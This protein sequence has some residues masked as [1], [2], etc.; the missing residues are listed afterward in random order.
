MRILLLL[1]AALHVVPARSDDRPAL[2]V[3]EKISGSVGFYTAEGRRIGGVKVGVHPH[4]IILSPDRRYAYVSDNGILW[5]TNPGEGGNTISIVDV[6]SMKKAGVV[7]LGNYRRPHG[8]DMDPRTG[9]LVVTIEN[10][11]GLLLVDPSERKVVRKYDVE[12]GDPH[13]VT[14][15]RDGRYAFVSNTATNTIAAVQLDTGKV[16]LIPTDARPQGGV[17]SHDG[18]RYYV[19]NADGNSIAIIDTEKKQRV[20]TIKSGRGAARV[21]LT[22][23]GKTLVYNLGEGGN[24]VAFADV[25]TLKET[26][27]LP[28]GGRPLSLTLSSDGRF[29]YAGIQDQDRI[30][31]VSV[32]ERKIVRVIETPKGAGP[33]PALPLN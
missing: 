19:A 16:I 12:G 27:V 29:A 5:M 22:P 8:M 25:A 21:A 6:K 28:I 24:A 14:L 33:D 4:E 15:S 11:D 31:V 2:V 1:L 20:G 30:V 17:L 23:D 9:R 13:M 26:T 3:V 32:P 18:K 10:P 7:S